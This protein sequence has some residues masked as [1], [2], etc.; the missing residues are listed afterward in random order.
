MSP[1]PKVASVIE[2]PSGVLADRPRVTRAHDVAGVALVPLA[3]HDLAGVEAARHRHLGHPRQLVLGRA[4]RRPARAAAARSCPRSSPPRSGDTTSRRR[5]ATALGVKPGS[6]VERPG[7]GEGCS[8]ARSSACSRRR[9][10]T[11]AADPPGE[12]GDQPDRDQHRERDQRDAGADGQHAPGVVR[13]LAER[14]RPLVL[15]GAGPAPGPA[16]IV[17]L[18]WLKLI[19]RLRLRSV[20]SGRSRSTPRRRGSARVRLSICCCVTAR[21]SCLSSAVRSARASARR[22]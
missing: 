16:L 8:Y 11:T 3:E 7:F 17:R 4:P 21:A 18:I 1:G 5:R 20:D 19:W 13:G 15:C 2:R 12:R 14:E 10:R 9:R 22:C 6:C